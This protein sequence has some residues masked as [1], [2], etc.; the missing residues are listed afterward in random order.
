MIAKREIRNYSEPV[1]IWVGKY[2][3]SHNLLHW[4]YD[5]E[6]LF[7][8][9]GSID[10][11]CRRKTHALKEGDALFL[12]RGEVH[13]MTA[14][15]E[16]TTLIVILFDYDI[17]RPYLGDVQLASPLLR[18]SYPIPEVYAK[19]RGLLLEKAPCSGVRAAAHIMLLMADVFAGEELSARETEDGTT[20]RFKE[21]MEH[22]SEKYEFFTFSDAAAFMGMSEGYFSRYFHAVTGITFPK[23]L[24]YVRTERAIELMQSGERS[25]TEIASLAGFGTIRNFN[26]VFREITGYAPRELPSDYLLTDGFVYP[27][28]APFDPTL[29]DCEL[30]EYAQG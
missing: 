8:E 5:C 27:T 11:F 10:V 29:R 19:V 2:K 20:K 21:L 15:D 14:R 3:H 12:G 13:Y 6:L 9:K 30:L 1:K 22:I 26:R 24:N 23:C 28:N 18:G 7:V 16:D 17:L 4:H 25:M